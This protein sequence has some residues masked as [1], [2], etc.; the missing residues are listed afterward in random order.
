ME[1]K[2]FLD[3]T[4]I[5]LQ[6]F[7]FYISYVSRFLNNNLCHFNPRNERSGNLLP[8]LSTLLLSINLLRNIL[9]INSF[10]YSEPL[11]I[12]EDMLLGG[13]LKIME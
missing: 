1:F 12:R 2:T 8:Q 13:L 10:Y 11:F 3:L 5:L 9:R 4:I 6:L 7:F